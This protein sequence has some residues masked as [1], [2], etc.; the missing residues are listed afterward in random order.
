[1]DI[2]M[3][4]EYRPSLVVHGW[5]GKYLASYIHSHQVLE[6]NAFDHLHRGLDNILGKGGYLCRVGHAM[7]RTCLVV[8][9][10]SHH[11]LPHK[12]SLC[13]YTELGIMMDMMYH[14]ILLV[15]QEVCMCREVG[16]HL[17]LFLRG[18]ISRWK[19]T[20]L[21]IT[22]GKECR[23]ILVVPQS[24]HTYLPVCIHLRHS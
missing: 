2:L 14:Y 3:G 16:N 7:A 10:H 20:S 11:L 6:D 9:T 17:H 5:A 23:H 1:M 12:V 21:G 19:H 8:D 4:M 22:M 24:V 15:P 18:K 13:H